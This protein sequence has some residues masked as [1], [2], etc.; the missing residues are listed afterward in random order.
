MAKSDKRTHAHMHT[1]MHG[2][3]F[4]I[5]P[6]PTSAGDKNAIVVTPL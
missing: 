3:H 5:P 2:R 4:I 1:Q 6:P